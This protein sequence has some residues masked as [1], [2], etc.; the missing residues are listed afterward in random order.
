MFFPVSSTSHLVMA[1]HWLI[2]RGSAMPDPSSPEMIL[3]DLLV[4]VGTLV[5]MAV[6]FRQSIAHF[7]T[8]FLRGLRNGF[9]RGGKAGAR[10]RMTL[11]LGLLGVFSVGVTGLIGFPLKGLF[12]EVFARP[13][14]I[15]GTLVVTGIL[16]WWTD[17]LPRRRRRLEE[18]GW[19]SAAVVGVAQGLALLPGLSRSGTTIAFGLF[20]GMKRRWAAEY[21]FFIAFPTIMGAS[22]LQAIEV[23]RAGEETRIDFLPLAVGFVVAALVGIVALRIVLRLLYR[24]RFRFFS[25]YVWALAAV[26]LLGV[27]QGWWPGVDLTH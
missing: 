26:I 23:W 2:S 11:R 24:A 17:V 6:V 27:A 5:S 15:A 25:Y 3:F 8:R 14:I 1:Q 16:L 9:R 7:L 19:G 21:S 22:L 4:H 12:E 13:G 18:V 10:E 20:A